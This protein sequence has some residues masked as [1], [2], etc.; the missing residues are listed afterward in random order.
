[1]N[2]SDRIIGNLL[3]FV[4][5]LPVPVPNTVPVS[6]MDSGD[7]TEAVEEPEL[8]ELLSIDRVT[9]DPE[10]QDLMNLRQKIVAAYLSRSR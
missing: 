3:D 5:N 10:Y 6:F 9:A 2:L 7:Y 8:A 1:M 4:D